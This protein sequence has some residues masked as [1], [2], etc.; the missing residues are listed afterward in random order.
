MLDREGKVYYHMGL[1]HAHKEENDETN[2]PAQQKKT[3]EKP[4]LSGSH[5]D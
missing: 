3:K 2:I 4:W 1:N 5:E